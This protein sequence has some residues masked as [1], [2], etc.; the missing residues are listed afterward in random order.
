MY[1]EMAPTHSPAF[2]TEHGWLQ[3]YN[4]LVMRL[5]KAVQVSAQTS[6]LDYHG[7]QTWREQVESEPVW[8]A[9]RLLDETQAM[10]G[11]LA[12][13][14]FEPHRAHFLLRH[15]RAF[16][17]VSRRLKGE[18]LSI[19][20][21]VLGCFDLQVDWLPES[22]FEQ[23]HDLYDHALPG[24]G[25]PAERL[26]RWRAQMTLPREQAHLLPRFMQRALSHARQRTRAMLPLPADE[27]VEIA[28]VFDR[29]VR[30]LADYLGKHRSR[31]LINPDIPFPLPDLFYVLCHEGYPGHLT[32]IMLK[33]E[34]LIRQCGYL[35]H[36]VQFLLTPAFVVSEGLALL[37]HEMIFEP[38]EQEQWLADHV[39]AEAGITPEHCNLTTI[40][41][42]QDLLRGVYCNAAFLL[43]EGRPD[44]EV[45][46]YL[47]RYALLEE[48]RARSAL[49]SLQRPYFEAYTFTYYHGRRLLE[50]RLRGSQRH[51]NL[52]NFLT[53]QVLPSE[54]EQ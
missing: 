22:L 5:D 20:N 29:P 46:D 16:E 13:Q 15:L 27:E 2:G 45:L 38:G 40:Y 51:Q 7:P 1:G 48:E 53:H 47:A 42:A 39:Y 24:W 18:P 34:A 3:D 17:T 35:E 28:P 30:G 11:M 31:I 4:L 49:Q 19:Q 21:E 9:A 33:E 54:L 10:G 32:E 44:R 43:R 23:A 26:Q 50:P 37:A 36:Q 12:E 14:G 52:L 25:N 41:R 6:L 8:D